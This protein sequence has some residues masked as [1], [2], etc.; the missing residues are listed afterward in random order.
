MTFRSLLCENR[1]N[2][3][4]RV[5]VGGAFVFAGTL[6]MA[7]PQ[8]FALDVSHYR[9]MPQELIHLVAIVIPGIEVVAGL[10]VLA[11]IR[12]KAAALVITG[13]TVVFSGVLV[14]ALAR[15]LNIECGC[16]GT[17]G[18]KHIGLVNLVIDLTL[19]CLAALLA[20]RA[21]RWTPLLDET[22]SIPPARG[23]ETMV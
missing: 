7:D 15:G 23:H 21:D 12:L 16:F 22:S 19:F 4:L 2:L 11:G 10:A 8:K 14:S 20:R 18:G 1:L 9:L 5:L 3:I 6:K 17:V 13:L